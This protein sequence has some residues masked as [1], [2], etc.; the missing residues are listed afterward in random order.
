MAQS[1]SWME[2]KVAELLVV[3]QDLEV[4]NRSANNNNPRLKDHLIEWEQWITHL[5]STNKWVTLDVQLIVVSNQMKVKLQQ[6]VVTTD[7]AMSIDQEVP[8]MHQLIQN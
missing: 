4:D 1:K 3:H 6:M 5:C 8:L 7:I 2:H